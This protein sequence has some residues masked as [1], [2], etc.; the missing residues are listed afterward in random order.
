MRST[1]SN[2]RGWRSESG[3]RIENSFSIALTRSAR[4]KESSSPDSKSDS[5]GEGSMGSGAKLRMMLTILVRLSMGFLVRRLQPDLLINFVLP[6]DVFEQCIGQAAIACGREM[7][8][9]K[10]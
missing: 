8:D 10:S 5:R 7:Q 6:Q 9:R 4:L 2:F 1:E 3:I